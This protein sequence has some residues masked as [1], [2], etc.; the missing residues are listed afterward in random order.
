VPVNSAD[1]E[2]AALIEERKPE[3]RV[4]VAAKA[5][6]KGK[7]IFASWIIKQC[8]PLQQRQI[9]SSWRG[10]DD[11]KHKAVKRLVQIIRC[12]TQYTGDGGSEHYFGFDA[13]EKPLNFK[14]IYKELTFCH[15]HYVQHLLEGLSIIVQCKEKTELKDCYIYLIQKLVLPLV[16]EE[17]NGP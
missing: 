12:E 4:D 13:D 2:Y 6:P 1:Q 5:P 17:P 11:C 9:A 8:S 15:Y 14:K 3:T 16:G 7:S 10:P